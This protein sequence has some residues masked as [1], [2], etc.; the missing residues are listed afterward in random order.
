METAN[1]Y[2]GLDHWELSHSAD[3]NINWRTSL[4][5]S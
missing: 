1:V 2:E 3:V 4:E 5:R